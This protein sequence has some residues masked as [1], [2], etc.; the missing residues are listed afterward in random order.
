MAKES[1]GFVAERLDW[2]FKNKRR[3]D[4]REYTYDEVAAATGLAKSYVWRIRYG[5]IKNPGRNALAALSKFF[6][7]HPAFWFTD[8]FEDQSQSNDR[9]LGR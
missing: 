6:G 4:G 9:S 1:P 8:V 5:E 2:L 7:V 3:E